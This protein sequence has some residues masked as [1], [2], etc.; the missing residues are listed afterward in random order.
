MKK[1]EAPRVDF[2]FGQGGTS[3]AFSNPV[4]DIQL[5]QTAL[6]DFQPP[7]QTTYEE[8]PSAPNGNF[9]KEAVMSSSDVKVE[10]EADKANKL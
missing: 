6:Q 4:F 5:A 2:A 9:P 8:N 10:L 3:V 1:G 7:G